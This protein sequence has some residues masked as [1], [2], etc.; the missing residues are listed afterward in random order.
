MSTRALTMAAAILLVW[1]LMAGDSPA[2]VV[3]HVVGRGARLSASSLDSNGATVESIEAIKAQVEAALGRAVSEDALVMARVIASEDAGGTEAAK[4]AVG[5]VLRNDA[6]AHGWS[7]RFTATANPGT[8]GRQDRGRR[9]STAGGGL[10]TREIHTD[11]L[12]IAE[13]VTSGEVADPTGGATKFV[14]YTGY[15]RFRDFLAAYPR[16]QAWVDGGLVPNFL[17]GVG[18]LVC[19]V[20]R[21]LV[22]SGMNTGGY[23]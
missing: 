3:R 21:D 20:P 14:H 10:G 11:D 9:Y 13:A 19:F 18:A 22:T 8:F 15:A 1:W 6:E 12:L 17:G 5:W 23:A 4:V 2:S 7:I 16:V